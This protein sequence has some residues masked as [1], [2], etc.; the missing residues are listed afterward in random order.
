MAI[1]L[2]QNITFTEVRRLVIAGTGIFP[3]SGGYLFCVVNRVA[4]V[5][6]TNLRRE[7]K[8]YSQQQWTVKQVDR[9]KRH[10]GLIIHYVEEINSAFGAVGV[11]LISAIFIRTINNSFFVL[12]KYQTQRGFNES[13][14][15]LGY[16]LIDLTIFTIL[17]YT[18]HTMNREVTN[19]Q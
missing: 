11:I 14:F 8:Q 16:M 15:S 10:Y 4:Y 17:I 5:M 1:A 12:V 2:L 9:V 7:T 6:M 13:L 19:L 18:S 3:S